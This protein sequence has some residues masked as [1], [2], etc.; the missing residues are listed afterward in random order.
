MS[1]KLAKFKIG[2]VVSVQTVA[3]QSFVGHVVGFTLNSSDETILVVR[4]PGAQLSP[5]MRCT[6]IL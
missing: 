5:G 3:G 6:T 4:R 1:Y 2:T